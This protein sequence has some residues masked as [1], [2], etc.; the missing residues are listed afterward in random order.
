MV[1]DLPVVEGG[2]QVNFSWGKGTKKAIHSTSHVW[3][4]NLLVFA[5]LIIIVQLLLYLQIRQTRN[6]FSL[7]V[8][9]HANMVAGIIRTTTDHAVQTRD[10]TEEIISDFLTG[11]ARFLDLLDRLQPLSIEELADY[12]EESGLTGVNL[13]SGAELSTG[14]PAN[15]LP[16]AVGTCRTGQGFTRY[17]PERSLYLLS[18]PR[19]EVGGCIQLAF[20][21]TEI[22]QMQEAIALPRLLKT[23]SGLEGINEVRLQPYGPGSTHATAVKSNHQMN[24]MQ[25]PL[26]YGLLTVTVDAT[27]FLA[28]SRQLWQKFVGFS[29]LLAILGLLSS[30]I[31]YRYQRATMERTRQ[32]ERQLHLQREDAALGRVTASVSHEIRN[33]LNA[34]SI[35]LQRMELEV[36]S[37]TSKQQRLLVS[38]QQAV[39]RT[40]GII[41]GLHRYAKPL[42]P[43]K[44]D[45]DIM[46]SCHS[47]VELFSQQAVLQNVDLFCEG[48]DQ[49]DVYADQELISQVLENLVK[50]AFEAQ[51]QGGMI[52]FFMQC[53][54]A[55]NITLQV[56]NG[57]TV[58]APGELEQ[59]LEPYFTTKTQGSGLGLPLS[60]RIVEA[61]GGSLIVNLFE[62]NYFQVTL[63]LPVKLV[64]IPTDIDFSFLE[65]S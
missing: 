16:D 42:H 43:L 14:F 50:N 40:D 56:I 25:I 26:E 64:D 18:W 28:G 11:H 1:E 17:F 45:F 7:H 27:Q 12:V 31:L 9:Q 58:V 59:C 65:T 49:L 41:N 6:L 38:M 35:G 46:E 57:P 52:K 62:G 55:D 39:K 30:M 51:P 33:P 37:L 15:W 23:L 44:V 5:T 4:T 22:D 63:C 34:I 47:I 3:K 48:P 10:V 53:Q 36:G 20:D 2:A 8:Q 29:L 60:K 19:A 21:M 61:H 13:Q 24:E 32:L 54:T